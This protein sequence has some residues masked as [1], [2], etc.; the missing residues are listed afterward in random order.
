MQLLID[1]GNTRLKWA[2]IEQQQ[3]HVGMPLLNNDLNEQTLLARWQA[4]KPPQQI[5]ISCVT[6]HQ[7]L[8]WLIS[9]ARHLWQN[10][11][12]VQVHAQAY[13]FAVTNAYKQPEK[14]G[15][16]RWLALIAARH[17][18]I[19]PVCIVDCG[20]A[21]TI[22][23]LD[24]NGQH[25][26]GFISPGLMLM[27]QALANGTSALP[28][29]ANGGTVQAANHTEAA[30][31][32]GTLLAAVGLIEQVINQHP[33]FTLLLTGGD[34]PLIVPHLTG[35]PI[36]DADLVLRGLAVVAKC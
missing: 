9:I 6:S 27:K 30:I 28:L 34:A 35:A 29:A 11:K 15:V 5:I 18:Y 16:D 20:T 25:L 7:R 17:H 4:L 31:Y 19:P 22:D 2:T 33:N 26:G 10:S 13:G 1:M 32:N 36:L 3:L 8:D 21:I 12:I 24:S 23:L 14:L